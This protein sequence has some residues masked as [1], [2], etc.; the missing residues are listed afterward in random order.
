MAENSNKERQEKFVALY[1]E[2]VEEGVPEKLA[3]E[4][5]KK[6]AGYAESTPLSSIL[7]TIG[8]DLVSHA[9]LEVKLMLP[10]ATKSLKSVLDDPE[11]KGAANAIAA[12]ASVYDRAGVL[13]KESKE[14]NITMPTGIAF[15][16]PKIPV[17]LHEETSSTTTSE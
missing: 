16:P 13:K 14:V 3:L 6:D 17:N 2:A 1:W 5:A 4:L 12:S 8:E 9:N 15:M 7:K 11:Q 10:K